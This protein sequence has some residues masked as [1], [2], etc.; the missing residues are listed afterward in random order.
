MENST[1]FKFYKYIP[2]SQDLASYSNPIFNVL[3][4]TNTEVMLCRTDFTE[5]GVPPPIS[6]LEFFSSLASKA[7]A[8]PVST[9]CAGG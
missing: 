6:A 3:R 4:L 9:H 5:N 8:K 1:I 7:G 2:N